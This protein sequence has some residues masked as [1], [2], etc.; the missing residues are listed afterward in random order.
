M[1]YLKD[2]FS[3]SVIR[4]KNTRRLIKMGQKLYIK[5]CFF[6]HIASLGANDER[7]RK[8]VSSKGVMLGVI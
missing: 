6:F 8:L 7:I 1:L 5:N 2:G 4:A 3:I